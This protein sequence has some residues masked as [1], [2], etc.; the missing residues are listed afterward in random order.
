MIF[1]NFLSSNFLDFKK[2]LIVNVLLKVHAEKSR[3]RTFIYIWFWYLQV[4]EKILD[5]KVLEFYK[6]DGQLSQML[7][8]VR[9]KLDQVAEVSFL[10][11]E[12]FPVCS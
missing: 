12:A 8:N 10:Y 9:D 2:I 3:C 6:W 4:A 5:K 1:K 7:Q 11:H